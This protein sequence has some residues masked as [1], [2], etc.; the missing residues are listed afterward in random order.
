[1]NVKNIKISKKGQAFSTFQLLIAAVVALALLGVLMPIIMQALGFIQSDPVSAAKQKITS[2]YDARG[3]LQTTE[4]VTFSSRNKEISATGL[5]E[6]TSLSSE[7]IFFFTNSLND[8]DAYG[9]DFGDGGTILEYTR[10]ERA[11]YYINII[12]DYGNNIEETLEQR[13]GRVVREGSL[14]N[15]NFDSVD[16]GDLENT[17]VCAVFP[18]RSN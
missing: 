12:C 16:S 4:E 6:G 15:I 13:E 2:A 5:S 8:F 1:M 7:Q 18:T 11:T 14:E 17:R 9:D 3:T 10:A